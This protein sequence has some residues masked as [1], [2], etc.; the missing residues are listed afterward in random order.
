MNITPALNHGI[1][2]VWN[3]IGFDVL[4]ALQAGGEPIDNE[5]A[6]ESVLDGGCFEMYCGDPEAI[7]DL[8]ALIKEQGYLE[9][10]AYLA[11]HHPLV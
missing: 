10:L 7:T 9:V 1:I 5:M 3:S 2:A 8:K 6:M 4:D 11:K